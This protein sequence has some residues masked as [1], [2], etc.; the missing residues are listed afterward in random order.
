MH[1]ISFIHQHNQPEVQDK[2]QAE[3]HE[4]LSK[5]VPCVRVV[6]SEELGET[7][8][9]AKTEHLTRKDL[10]TSPRGDLGEEAKHGIETQ[11]SSFD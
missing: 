9:L 2:R 11:I 8:D 6:K 5:V 3:G 7:E 4:E 10:L 1:R